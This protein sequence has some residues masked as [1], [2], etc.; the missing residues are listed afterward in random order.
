MNKKQIIKI[1]VG[2]A[3]VVVIVVV[4]FAIRSGETPKS[5]YTIE[6]DDGKAKLEISQ[7]AIPEGVD[8][9]DISVTEVLESELLFEKTEGEE[10]IAYTLEP[11]GLGF[12]EDILFKV[13]FDN[14]LNTIPMLYQVV[15]GNAIETIDDIYIEMDL[16]TKKTTVSA[17]I[18]H[19]SEMYLSGGYS[20]IRSAKA[21]FS[22]EA[23]IPDTFVGETAAGKA[24]ISIISNAIDIRDF[25]EWAP[26]A[27][28]GWRT[29]LNP[30]S[31]R[32]SGK[33]LGYQNLSPLSE[34][35]NRPPITAFFYDTARIPFAGN[36]YSIPTSDYV[37]EDEGP[38][39][40][41]FEVELTWTEIR[42]TYGRI[43]FYL[44]ETKKETGTKR[45]VIGV[46]TPFEC[47]TP[48][49][50]TPPVTTPPKVISTYPVNGA[51][52]IT[53]NLDIEIE[54]DVPMDQKSTEAAILI[55]PPDSSIEPLYSWSHG[56]R[57]ITNLI[58]K[59]ELEKDTVYE[60]YISTEAKSEQGDS[61]KEPYKFS[62]TTEKEESSSPDRGGFSSGVDESGSPLDPGDIDPHFMVAETGTQARVMNTPLPGAYVPNDAAS[63]WIWE[64]ANGKPID[65][66]RT[67]RTS[68]D[69]YSH[70]VITAESIPEPKQLNIR[71]SVDNTLLDVKLNGISTGISLEGEENY[72]YLRSFTLRGLPSGENY[73]DFVVKDV[74]EISGFRVELSI[75]PTG[76]PPWPTP[77][78]DDTDSTVGDPT[79]WHLDID[80]D[81]Y[82]DPFV[83]QE[84]CSQPAG[85]VADNTD[86][87]DNDV[88]VFEITTWYLDSDGDGYADDPVV[89]Q[90]ACSQPAGYVAT[91]FPAPSATDCDKIDA[92]G[93][94]IYRF[95][96][97]VKADSYQATDTGIY[98]CE[99][100]TVD[101]SVDPNQTWR[102]SPDEGFSSNADGIPWYGQFT[103]DGFSAPYGALV[104]EIGD[105][106]YFLI[107]TGYITYTATESAH[108]RLSLYYW[109]DNFP[110]NSGQIVVEIK[111]IK[112]QGN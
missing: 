91:D 82:G 99:G 109:D 67:F 2:L 88:T 18:S 31:L 95:D 34:I 8:I 39:R 77:D 66:V 64:N 69:P 27:G 21:L 10:L 6:S 73:L 42:T 65:V 5:V 86:C 14:T 52:D 46:I 23:E 85:Y 56:N 103:H 55:K 106:N 9:S 71:V 48:P 54:F 79:T 16:A 87:D 76:Q 50:T 17:P 33:L 20:S 12:E 7:G 84:A 101:F 96:V 93:E 68:F 22:A 98:L 102:A 28:A 63:Q 74:G 1:V 105:G 24:I 36:T 112:N 4:F 60:V 100:D 61:L 111:A 80:G 32:I 15:N 43:L 90:E 57:K 81:G 41:T 44:H 83:S 49:V 58:N 29:V 26:L 70:D 11:D 51:E 104:G 19:F 13:T 108:G 110:N 107:G 89:T 78:C 3:V 38:T 75:T 40:I 72:S 45:A 92:E 37:C 30:D 97:V 53:T 62:F 35:S 47:V 25:T 59:G 94:R